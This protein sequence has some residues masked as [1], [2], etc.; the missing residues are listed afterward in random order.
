MRED[1]EEK[2]EVRPR[3]FLARII[4]SKSWICGELEG[5]VSRS[6]MNSLKAVIALGV[7]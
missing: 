3:D 2:K 6:Q 5:W 1:L 7:V 4:E